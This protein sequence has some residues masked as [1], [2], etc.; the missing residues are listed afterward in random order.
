VGRARERVFLLL[1]I[2]FGLMRI[3]LDERIKYLALKKRG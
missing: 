2:Y 3:H 1:F